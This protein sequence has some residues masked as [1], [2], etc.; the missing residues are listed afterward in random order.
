M[1][2]SLSAIIQW[3]APILS[4]LIVTA[5]TAQIN[6][7]AKRDEERRTKSQ[8]AFDDERK[9]WSEW[10]KRIEDRFAEQDD[11]ILAI[12]ESQCTQM[13]SDITHKVHRYMDDLHCASEEE[14]QSLQAEYDLYCKI[15]RTYGIE[16]HFVERMVQQVMEL[17]GRT[18]PQF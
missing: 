12:L 7:R 14:K 11:T 2:D 6:A 13:R 4:T 3:L 18:P 16:N 1:N 8:Q 5:L 15:C 17:P 9:E 10:R